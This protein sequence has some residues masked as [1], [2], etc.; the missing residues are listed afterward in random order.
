MLYP[1]SEG[2]LAARRDDNAE[3]IAAPSTSGNGSPPP[4]NQ[5]LPYPKQPTKAKN[6]NN[7]KE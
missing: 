4:K 3:K 1:L 2:A 5:P 7:M 6:H